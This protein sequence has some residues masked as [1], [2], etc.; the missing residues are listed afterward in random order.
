MEKAFR[1]ERLSDERGADGSSTMGHEAPLRGRTKEEA[2]KSRMTEVIHQ[3][4]H[5]FGHQSRRWTLAG[6]L[7]TGGWLAC[8]SVSGLWRLLRRWNIHYK[9]A[10]GTCTARAKDQTKGKTKTYG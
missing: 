4:P 3:D 5:H 10:R 8:K 1:R 7:D 6:L 2:A 9:R